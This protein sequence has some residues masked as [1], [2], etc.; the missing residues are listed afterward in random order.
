MY[1]ALY[2]ISTAIPYSIISGIGLLLANGNIYVGFYLGLFIGLCINLFALSYFL[3]TLFVEWRGKI[4]PTLVVSLLYVFSMFTLYN[5]FKSV[6]GIAGVSA[7]G[8]LL[9]LAEAVKLYRHM[10][11]TG[12]FTKLDSA[13]LGV[14][15]AVSSQVPPN[16]FRFIIVEGAIVVGLLFLAIIKQRSVKTPN[17]KIVIRNFIQ[18]VPIIVIVAVAGMMYWEWY[19]FSSFKTNVGVSVQA[20]QSFGLSTLNAPYANLINT[21]RVFGVW[22]FQTGYCPYY[23]LFYS[24]SVITITSFLW[25]IVALGMSLLLIKRNYRLRILL[26]VTFSLLVIAW[27]SANNPPVGAINLFA[28]S[29]ITLLSS[30]FPTFFLSGTFLPLIYIVLCTFVVIRLTELLRGSKR[31][32]HFRYKKFAMIIPILLIVLLLIPDAPFFTGNALEQYFNPNIKGISIPND[33]FQVKNILSSSIQSDNTVLLW[34]SITTYIQTSWGYQGSNSFY[35][36][37][38]TPLTI[39]TPDSFGGYSL[40]NPSLA[41]E[42]STLTSVPLT[43]GDNSTDITSYA[44]FPEFSVQGANYTYFNDAISLDSVNSSSNYVYI[45]IPFNETLNTSECA[46]F[47]VQFSAG[48]QSVITNLLKNEGLWIGIGSSDGDIGWYIPGSTTS[49]NYTINNNLFTLSMLAGSPNKP[50]ALSEYNASFVNKLVFS[51]PAEDLI[52]NPNLSLSLSSIS[53]EAFFNVVN[54]SII[55]LWQQYK[56]EYIMFDSSNVGGA[57]ISLEQYSNC[58]SF[59]VNRGV[60]IPVFMGEYLQLYKVNYE[61]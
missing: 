45:V 11:K 38:F 39:F 8:F 18:T 35:N 24:N 21:F 1:N 13:L 47:T 43:A 34:P 16:C 55:N 57:T 33:Y 42:Y 12:K 50:W 29:H 5:T 7:A 9:F 20:A 31:S 48:P 37:F 3:N 59:L 49:S 36:N 15:I 41:T 22:A 40:T 61:V 25:P 60:L 46:L 26:L 4:M 58:L 54:Q 44:N 28:V 53:I 32:F 52:N 27:D 23:G 17:I 51:I 6:I 19:F 14:G 30:V 2:S 56:V 10:S